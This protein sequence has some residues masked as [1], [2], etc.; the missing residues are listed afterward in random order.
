MYRI[1]IALCVCACVCIPYIRLADNIKS[2]RRAQF[3]LVIN[4]VFSHKVYESVTLMLN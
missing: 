3:V 2:H 4:L 1:V